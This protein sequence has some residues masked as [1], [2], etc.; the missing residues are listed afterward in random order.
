VKYDGKLITG[1]RFNK[2]GNREMYMNCAVVD[3][4]GASSFSSSRQ[5]AS[6]EASSAAVAQAALSRYPDLYVAN[7]KGVNDCVTR[8]TTDVIFD[9]PGADVVYGDGLSASSSRI[10]RRTGSCTGAGRTVVASFGSD[11]SSSGSFAGSSS[12]SNSGSS[13]SSSSSMDG[14]SHSNN[15]NSGSSSSSGSS[16]SSSS[17]GGSTGGDDG[18]W[19]PEKY[20]GSASSASSSSSGGDDGQWHPDVVSFQSSSGGSKSGGSGQS[21]PI[22]ISSGSSS[23]GS[24]SKSDSLFSSFNKAPSIEVEKALAAYLKSIGQDDDT[25]SVSPSEREDIPVPKR[26]RFSPQAVDTHRSSV[27]EFFQY[28]PDQGS[29]PRF[30]TQQI[31]S[32]EPPDDE[33]P[34]S[35]PNAPEYDFVNHEATGLDD[36]SH[37]SSRLNDHSKTP[38]FEVEDSSSEA[39]NKDRFFGGDDGDN[40]L[41]DFLKD[42]ISSLKDENYGSDEKGDTFGGIYDRQKQAK[43][44]KKKKKKTHSSSKAKHSGTKTS[45][46][47]FAHILDTS[48]T[49][50]FL[51]GEDSETAV[52]EDGASKSED[53]ATTSTTDSKA[54]AAPTPKAGFGVFGKAGAAPAVLFNGSFSALAHTA[55]PTGVSTQ[56][57][58]QLAALFASTE[59]SSTTTESA[60]IATEA[61]IS[62]EEPSVGALFTPVKP[63]PIE[64]APSLAAP[65]I[66]APHV[67]ASDF[68]APGGACTPGIFLCNGEKQFWVCGQFGGDGW[69]YGALRDVSGG[70]TC[71]DGKIDRRSVDRRSVSKRGFGW[72]IGQ[73]DSDWG[74]DDDDES[75]LDPIINAID[76]L[77]K[78][79]PRLA[80]DKKKNQSD[81]ATKD[82]DDW[83]QPYS[84]LKRKLGWW[85]TNSSPSNE[86]PSNPLVTITDKLK[87]LESTLDWT[88]SDLSASKNKNKSQKR[89][90]GW[91]LSFGGDDTDDEG[92]AS[93][94]KN[95]KGYTSDKKGTNRDPLDDILWQVNDLS[96]KFDELKSLSRDAAKWKRDWGFF[97]Q[98]GKDDMNKEVANGEL[99]D[100]FEPILSKLKGYVRLVRGLL[101]KGKGHSQPLGGGYQYSQ[102]P[103]Y[104]WDTQGGNG[105]YSRD[106]RQLRPG[107]AG[108]GV[109][110][111]EDFEDIIGDGVFDF[112]SDEDDDDR[113]AGRD[114]SE[115][116]SEDG[117]RRPTRPKHSKRPN[118]PGNKFATI[119]ADFSD[120]DEDEDEDEP[121][122]RDGEKSSHKA[123]NHSSSRFSTQDRPQR[124][125]GN[126]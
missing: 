59:S 15:A 51:L 62:L 29:D 77:I 100:P 42:L 106:K 117:P 18:M 5:R 23:A 55:F 16:G 103:K 12:S 60:S 91:W 110:D 45:K 75:P 3:L 30:R 36:D 90:S 125:F 32:R 39:A 69:T 97:G 93:S 109:S 43:K 74:S 122:G 31:H 124:S 46:C 57:P 63:A 84:L 41:P 17:S 25:S 82:S 66:E 83:Y 65:H 10:K 8:E 53:A 70:M 49:G 14:M 118:R 64:A 9:N 113:P 86:V 2:I 24:S 107:D 76:T 99:G 19:H 126:Q 81:Y 68:A 119:P 95:N 1:R 108:D 121:L 37:S 13:S 50:L 54:T 27:G 7:L 101:P 105:W 20:A 34:T 123:G 96:T 115:D 40:K 44:E 94:N 98:Y 72:Y 80:T 85:I 35:A 120:D 92:Y 88:I 89:S 67:V 33:K 4:V 116:E 71:K 58:M 48:L 47:L 114:E 87:K 104:P 79:V 112:S 111:S 78:T 6:T 61:I 28:S 22:A 26:S 73:D 11:S 38:S 56:H 21:Q 52:P 102:R